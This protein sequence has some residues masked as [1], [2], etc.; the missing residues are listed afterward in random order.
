MYF[1]NQDVLDVLLP[2]RKTMQD[3]VTETQ[4]WS[5]NNVKVYCSHDEDKHNSE[6]VSSTSQ[7]IILKTFTIIKHLQYFSTV[8]GSNK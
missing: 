4:Q 6:S 1:E 3:V 2:V 7:N 5:N 8:D